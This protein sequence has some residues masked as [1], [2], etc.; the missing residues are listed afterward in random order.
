MSP[1]RALYSAYQALNPRRSPTPTPDALKAM[2]RIL[3]ECGNH[4]R[5]VLYLRWVAES[6]DT[7]AMQ[8][9][10][11]APWPGGDL[12][13]RCDPVSL[14][15]NIPGRLDAVD[16]WARRTGTARPANDA[17][18]LTT[19]NPKHAAALA[20]LDAWAPSGNVNRHPVA[21]DNPERK[22]A[23]FVAEVLYAPGVGGWAAYY[24]DPDGTRRRFL[25]AMQARRAA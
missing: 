24:A 8:L 23:E 1:P 6:G 22:Q 15:R 7:Y 2:N 20:F 18:P 17:P 12:T 13:P 21:R 4:D 9:R 25:A 14:S 11:L 16:A 3:A 19:D 10:G 5:A